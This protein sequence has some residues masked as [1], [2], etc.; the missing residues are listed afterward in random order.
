MKYKPQ[1]TP[2]SEKTLCEGHLSSVSADDFKRGNSGRVEVANILI[3]K[4]EGSF[5]LDDR[6]QVVEAEDSV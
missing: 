1:C 5:L 4:V 6:S 2:E 3:D